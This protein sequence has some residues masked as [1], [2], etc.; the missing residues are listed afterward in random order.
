MPR[1]ELIAAAH[2]KFSKRIARL[3]RLTVLAFSLLN[4]IPLMG[5]IPKFMERPKCAFTHNRA[6][7]YQQ[8]FITNFGSPKAAQA[9][10]TRSS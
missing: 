10:V 5:F 3:E 2:H 8:R 4:E 6:Q 9:A 7:C 1:E